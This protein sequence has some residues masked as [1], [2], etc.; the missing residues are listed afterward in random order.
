MRRIT[1]FALIL[2]TMTAT[3]AAGAATTSA[4]TTRSAA[5]ALRSYVAW[6]MTT[7]RVTLTGCRRDNPFFVECTAHWNG[8]GFPISV[9]GSTSGSSTWHVSAWLRHGRLICD[10]MGTSWGRCG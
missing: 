2:A 6:Q 9:N 3:S 7:K 5:R 8:T 10:M 1:T 4:L